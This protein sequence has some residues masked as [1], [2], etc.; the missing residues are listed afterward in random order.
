M[1]REAGHSLVDRRCSNRSTRRRSRFLSLTG[2]LGNSRLVR[3]LTP[4]SIFGCTGLTKLRVNG[5]CSSRGSASIARKHGRKRILTADDGCRRVDGRLNFSTLSQGPLL[6][7]VV[8]QPVRACGRLHVV[9]W[10]D[11][12]IAFV[13]SQSASVMP[14]VGASSATGSS[15]SGIWR[16]RVHAGSHQ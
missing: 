12:Q 11:F 7:S 3:A 8:V 1:A 13:P 9:S 2:S 6:Y 4:S 15:V 14:A 16:I 10:P 5:S